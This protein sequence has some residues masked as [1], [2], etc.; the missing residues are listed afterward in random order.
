MF[1]AVVSAPERGP[2]RELLAVLDVMRKYL[3]D[4]GFDLAEA[5]HRFD[6]DKNGFLTHPEIAKMTA[7]L[8][9]TLDAEELKHVVHHQ[10][11]GPVAAFS[12]WNFPLSQ[13]ARKVAG[14]LASGCSIILKAAEETPAGAIHIVQA[15]HDVGL[16]PG[17]LNLVFGVSAA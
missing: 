16:P 10:P 4:F 14:A 17:V 2:S 8:I 7:R 9:P 15:F 6:E 5:F 12:P 13:P 1:G 11:I 3:A